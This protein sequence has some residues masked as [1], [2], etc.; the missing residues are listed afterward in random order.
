VDVS[1]QAA[2]GTDKDTVK[3]ISLH[4]SVQVNC[5]IFGE[6]STC[7]IKQTLSSM[8]LIA[9]ASSSG[10]LSISGMAWLATVGFGAILADG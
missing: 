8:R 4:G 10:S 7:Q 3:R 2:S 9:M 1:R 5:F 6:L